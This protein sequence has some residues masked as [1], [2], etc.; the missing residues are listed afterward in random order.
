MNLVYSLLILLSVVA[1]PA[2][3]LVVVSSKAIFTGV[4]NSDPDAS[5][6]DTFH[7]PRNHVTAVA[8]V[9]EGFLKHANFRP[10]E[11]GY[12]ETRDQYYAFERAVPTFEYFVEKSRRLGVLKLTGDL[13]Q[14]QDAIADNYEPITGKADVTASAVA[15]SAFAEQ[16]PQ[17]VDPALSG[18]WNPL[19]SLFLVLITVHGGED[20]KIGVDISAINVHI[21]IDESTGLVAIKEQIANLRQDTFQ[22]DPYGFVTFTERFSMYQ[23]VS[24]ANILDDLS[25]PKPENRTIKVYAAPTDTIIAYR[26]K[27]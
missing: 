25:T 24:V 23:K 6:F 8:S 27:G 10:K 7:D 20:N 12:N 11:H 22:L 14:F 16:I 9:I 1:I 21:D 2:Q 18:S 5:A 4:D 3:A 13:G 17:Y 26:N 15:A 19:R